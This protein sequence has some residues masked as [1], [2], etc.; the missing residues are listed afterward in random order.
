MAS[1][2]TAKGPVKIKQIIPE[3]DSMQIKNYLLS[4]KLNKDLAYIFGDPLTNQRLIQ[5]TIPLKRDSFIVKGSIPNP[6]EFLG[7]YLK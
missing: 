7:K 4:S 1:P 6:P 2:D 5:G 3:I